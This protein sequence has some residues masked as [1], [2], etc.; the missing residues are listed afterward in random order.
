MLFRRCVYYS[1]G[2]DDPELR[3]FLETLES[4]ALKH[5]IVCRLLAKLVPGDVPETVAGAIEHAL[6]PAIDFEAGDIDRV[7]LLVYEAV[8]L[9][10][11]DG[12]AHPRV[13][14]L[15]VED[16]IARYIIDT[17]VKTMSEIELRSKSLRVLAK[18]L[19]LVD[20]ASI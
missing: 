15:Q 3:H 19:L 7:A 11:E 12:A 9:V 8:K 17:N 13:S 18:H 20:E 5:V 14:L 10:G 4:S 1:Q 16:F 6:A 2:M